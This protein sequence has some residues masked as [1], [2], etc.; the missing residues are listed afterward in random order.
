M[1]KISYITLL[2][3]IKNNFHYWTELSERCTPVYEEQK[4]RAGD[5]ETGTVS[6]KYFMP[7]AGFE[8]T[9]PLEKQNSSFWLVPQITWSS[10]LHLKCGD[11]SNFDFISEEW[12]LSYVH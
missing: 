7:G 10:R 5:E 12:N 6:E 11:E 2:S 3:E 9:L 1:K 8:P 4:G